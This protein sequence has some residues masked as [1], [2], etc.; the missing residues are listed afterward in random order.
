MP[1]TEISKTKTITIR[2]GPNTRANVERYAAKR[3]M[4]VGEFVR[5][6]VRVYMDSTPEDDV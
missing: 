1:K 6:C 5:Y 4:S 3:E 2:L